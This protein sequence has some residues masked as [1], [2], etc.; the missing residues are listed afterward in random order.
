MKGMRITKDSVF[1]VSSEDVTTTS[2]M[3]KIGSNIA[4]LVYNT[5]ETE[6][7]LL[8]IC[9][10]TTGESVHVHF[11]DSDVDVFDTVVSTLALTNGVIGPENRD[12]KEVSDLF[13]KILQ[14][15]SMVSCD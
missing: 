9:N 13:D 2:N 14:I 11:T 8:G 15:R 3:I 5:P 12:N 4:L 10:V 6:T 1:G 7:T